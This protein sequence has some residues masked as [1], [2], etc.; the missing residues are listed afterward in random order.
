MTPPTYKGQIF[1]DF[2]YTRYLEEAKITETESRIE[3]G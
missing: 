1:Y 3:V 2:T